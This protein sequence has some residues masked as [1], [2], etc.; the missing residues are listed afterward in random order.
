METLLQPGFLGTGV[1]LLAD[2]ILALYGLLAL[3]TLIFGLVII[4]RRIE[5]RYAP[6][7]RYMLTAITLVNWA[8]LALLGAA[9]ALAQTAP[10]LLDRLDEPFYLVVFVMLVASVTAQIV[11]SLLVARMWFGGLAPRWVRVTDLRQHIA[12]TLLLWMIT[13]APGSALAL[14]WY[15]AQPV[16]P[17]PISADALGPVC[18]AH[19]EVE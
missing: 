16:E 11:L 3:P 13:A 4:G 9:T 12:L 14:T 8:L 19:L 18:T 5:G 6:H 10:P 15:T 1:S 2:V 7:H 17:P